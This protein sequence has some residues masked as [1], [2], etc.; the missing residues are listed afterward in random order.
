MTLIP[1][2]LGLRVLQIPRALEERRRLEVEQLLRPPPQ[3]C[4]PG[5][6]S[7]FGPVET[8][9]FDCDGL[10]ESRF[11]GFRALGATLREFLGLGSVVVAVP[12]E[13]ILRRFSAL[14]N[15]GFRWFPAAHDEIMN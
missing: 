3:Q 13:E 15:G 8:V 10:F 2:E 12:N 5:L 11:K 14:Q 4:S 1:V 6:V 9:G 7:G